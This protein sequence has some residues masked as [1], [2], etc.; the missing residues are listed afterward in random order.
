MDIPHWSKVRDRRVDL[1][2]HT[3]GNCSRRAI[4]RLRARSTMHISAAGAYR[5]HLGLR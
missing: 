4:P 5:Y 2:G 1:N 3:R